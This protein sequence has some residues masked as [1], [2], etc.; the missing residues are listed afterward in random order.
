MISFDET[1]GLTNPS[2]TLT[3]DDKVDALIVFL[4]ESHLETH[5][6]YPHDCMELRGWVIVADLDDFKDRNQTILRTYRRRTL[7]A[8]YDAA[9]RMMGEE[10]DLDIVSTL[11]ETAPD[12]D[13][14]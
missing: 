4:C 6:G 8:W 14:P 2:L 1:I 11:F 3:D 13:H 9:V 12:E 7:I 10:P 5:G